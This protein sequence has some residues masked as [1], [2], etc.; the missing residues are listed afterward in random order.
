MNDTAETGY[1]SE[2]LQEERSDLNDVA[3]N[4]YDTTEGE[5]DR[6]ALPPS[7]FSSEKVRTYRHR[8]QLY[9]K[10][11][12]TSSIDARYMT[13]VI[14]RRGEGHADPCLR[15]LEMCTKKQNDMVASIISM[16][17]SGKSVN[18]IEYLVCA[19]LSSLCYFPSSFSSINIFFYHLLIADKFSYNSRPGTA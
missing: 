15:M 12:I 4:K 10:E 19:V 16:M 8:S 18:L 14:S 7:V 5:E 11:A 6:L 2:G 9:F 1:V 3:N 17:K 13:G